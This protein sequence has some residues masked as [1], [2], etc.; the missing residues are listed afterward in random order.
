[1][2]S[3]CEAPVDGS[4]VVLASNAEA[5]AVMKRDIPRRPDDAEGLVTSEENVSRLAEVVA[6]ANTLK[7]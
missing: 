4:V 6:D 7:V 1:V 2:L 3:A 5:T